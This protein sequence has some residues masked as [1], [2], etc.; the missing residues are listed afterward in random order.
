M[1]DSGKKHSSEDIWQQFNEDRR[2]NLDTR[3]RVSSIEAK[4][5]NVFTA[6][7][8]IADKVHNKPDTNWIGIGVLILAL[9]TA[10]GTYINT[11]LSPTEVR[12]LAHEEVRE[13]HTRDIARIE[14]KVT[15][16]QRAIV[17]LEADISRI[18][19]Q[20]TDTR[21][22]LGQV[23]GKLQGMTINGERK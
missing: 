1:Q 19:D 8:Q 10:S 9:G 13:T 15:T 3:E 22:R 23:E 21:T 20:M 5:D 14:Q 2:L 16:E 6:I 18:K 17:M 12:V 4:L 11:R 7:Q